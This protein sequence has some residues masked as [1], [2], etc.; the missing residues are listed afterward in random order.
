MRLKHVVAAGLLAAAGTAG[1]GV[2]SLPNSGSSALVLSVWDPVRGVSYNR[3]L[4][5]DLDSFLSQATTGPG[6]AVPGFDPD[7]GTLPAT[8]G[9]T[10][11]DSF[12]PT[13][14]ADV[15]FPATG[16]QSDLSDMLW[17][18]VAADSTTGG[19]DDIQRLLLTASGPNAISVT[20]Q[21]LPS[22][23]NNVNNYFTLINPVDSAPDAGDPKFADKASF[24]ENL[25][26]NG[27]NNAGGVDEQLAMLL[28]TRNSELNGVGFL[29]ALKDL[30]EIN[31]NGLWALDG[32]TGALTFTNPVPLP[33]AVWLFLATLAGM[34]GLARRRSG[35]ASALPA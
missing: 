30:I 35:E 24:G 16:T 15:F 20:N 29:P 4:G 33:P 11:S 19:T 28:V 17:N 12:D 34:A 8:P 23:I 14:Y 21:F 31:P 2:S 7:T 6:T 3:D 27:I 32:L 9:F 18:V 22:A 25:G 1:A 13:V 10:F 5:I 26:V